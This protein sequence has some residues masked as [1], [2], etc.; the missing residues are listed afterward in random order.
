MAK[1][2]EQGRA[3]VIGIGWRGV[4]ALSLFCAAGRAGAQF[5]AEPQKPLPPQSVIEACWSLMSVN[6]GWTVTQAPL[7]PDMLTPHTNTWL[8]LM[9][10]L[11]IVTC[12]GESM[13]L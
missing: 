10:R 6:A 1:M 3:A 13:P 7:A 8:A 9:L 4:L 5:G 2:A 12:L 11:R